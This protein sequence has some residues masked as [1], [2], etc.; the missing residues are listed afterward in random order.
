MKITFYEE[1]TFA[2]VR[3]SL[4]RNDDGFRL[5]QDALEENPRRGDVIPGTNGAR[6]V[7]WSDA[8]R[9]MGKRGGLRII[10]YYLETASA[11]LLLFAYNK[12][13]PDLTPAQKKLIIEL[14]QDFQEEK[15]AE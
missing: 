1:I 2:R 13:T 7:R 6:K 8:G 10:Y 15:S 11:L 12:N 3:D 9:G 5:F 14:I 4:F